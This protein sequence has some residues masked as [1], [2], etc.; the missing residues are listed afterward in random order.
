[1]VRVE[2]VA[3]T[4]WKGKSVVPGDAAVVAPAVSQRWE[5]HGIAKVVGDAVDPPVTVGSA[6]IVRV[7]TSS[8]YDIKRGGEVLDRVQGQAKAEARAAELST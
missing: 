1:M 4:R 3:R 2:F 6:T 5:R 7:G 8:W